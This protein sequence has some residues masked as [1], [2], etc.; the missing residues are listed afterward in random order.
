MKDGK[1]HPATKKR[2]PTQYVIKNKKD[3]QKEEVEELSYKVLTRLIFDDRFSTK[4]VITT[5]SGR[6]VG[7]SAVRSELS[8]LGG[9]VKVCTH[10]NEGT[11]FQFVIP[12]NEAK[13]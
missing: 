8:K 10:Q 6:G 5:V 7:L 1:L 9:D 3:V 11:K 4:T 12:Y 2:P 13:V